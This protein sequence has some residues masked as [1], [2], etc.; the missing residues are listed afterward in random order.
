[1]HTL[2]WKEEQQNPSTSFS[3]SHKQNVL[4]EL[5]NSTVMVEVKMKHME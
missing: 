2:H 4:N 1:M 5:L 3:Q